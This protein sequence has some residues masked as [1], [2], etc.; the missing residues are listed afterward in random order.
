[1]SKVTYVYSVRNLDTNTKF[2]KNETEWVSVSVFVWFSKSCAILRV[3]LIMFMTL[4][5]KT[6]I[7]TYI[8]IY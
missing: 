5:L 7:L 2:K 1:V 6:I 8:Y 4:L 3:Q